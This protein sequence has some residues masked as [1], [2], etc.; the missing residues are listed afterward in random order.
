[1]INESMLILAGGFGKR[2]RSVVSQ[3][4]KPLAPVLDKTFLY[5]LIQQWVSQGVRS[6]VFLLHHQSSL[7]EDFLSAE[8]DGILKGAE[9]FTVT[10]PRPLGTG[11]AVAYAV[12][13]LSLEGSFLVANADTWLGTGVVQLVET[14]PPALTVVKVKNSERYGAVRFEN[15]CVTAF[16][17]KDQSAGPGWIN[18]GLC[19][20]HADMFLGR[21]QQEF[22]LERELFPQLVYENK[23]HAV[24]LETDF[25]DIGIPEDYRRFCR[26]IESGKKLG[27]L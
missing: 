10:E 11:G 16:D 7:I 19:Y 15:N 4:P 8:S 13:Q 2:L 21:G 14:S 20:L 24:S 6:F 26:W 27:I 23:L 3:V 1:M 9:V 18:A 17:E 25:I 5:H 12:Q 22:S